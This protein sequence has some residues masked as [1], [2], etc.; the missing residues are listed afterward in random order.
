M[1]TFEQLA[2]LLLALIARQQGYAIPGHMNKEDW[3]LI[4]DAE[5]KATEAQ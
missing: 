2:L 1:T 4:R 5:N 3:E